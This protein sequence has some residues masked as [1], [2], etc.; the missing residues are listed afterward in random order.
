RPVRPTG[1]RD[2]PRRAAR[3]ASSTPGPRAAA[4]DPALPQVG[5]DGLDQ[6][7]ARP[8]D[9]GQPPGGEDDEQADQRPEEDVVE[10]DGDVGEDHVEAL[11]DDRARQWSQRR[12]RTAEE[13]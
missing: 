11:E 7:A 10:E 12:S 3:R 8:E 6:A 5:A 4:S 13:G 9:L 1:P 2:R